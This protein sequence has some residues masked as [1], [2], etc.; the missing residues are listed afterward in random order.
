MKRECRAHIYRISIFC[1]LLVALI[2]LAGCT[3]PEKAK[4]QHLAAGEAYL[5]D[6]KYQEASLEFRNA[7]QIDE[8]LAA[9]H[10][11]LARSFEGLERFP[12]MLEELRKTVSLDK[13]N[14]DARV[15]LGTYYLGGSRGQAE[16]L[17]EAERLAKEILAKDPNHIE[18]HILMGGVL[19]A[20]NQKDK[21]FAELN[22]AVELDPKR[23]E[24]YLSL[25]KFYIVTND[26]DKAEETYRKAISIS[27]QS[28]LAHSEY[29]KFLAQAN[30]QS[31]AEAELRKAVELGPKDRGAH[32]V[33]ASYYF[34]NKQL[35]KAEEAY[36]ALAALD[37]E[38]PESQA[39]LADF[40]SAVNRGDDAVR[41]YKDILS[42][43]PDFLQA[44][45]RL[46][47]ILFARGDM[48]GAN[49]Q[50]AEVFKKDEH[51]RRALLLRAQMR[52]Q[53]RQQDGLKAAIEDLKEVLRQEPNS[54]DGLYYMA[55]ANYALG[56]FDQA[57]AF[58][59]ELEKNYPDYLP[60][61]LLQVE[62]ALS[63]GDQNDYKGAVTLA[64]DLLS[65]LDKTV[66]DNRENTAQAL[67][68]I[69]EAAYLTRGMAQLQLKNIPGARQDF[70]AARAIGPYDPVVHTSLALVALAENKPQDAIAS[71]EAA[72][73]VDA[74]NFDA[75]NGLITL[76][77]R[78]QDVGKAQATIDQAL[79]A[80]PNVA[81]LH[82]L[83]AL[84]YSF[85]HN[86]QSVEAELNRALELDPN[87]L[88]AYSGLANLYLNTKQEDRAI[89]QYQKII[90]LR[91]EN[92]VPYTLIGILEHQRKNYEVAAQNY[93]KA[94]EKDPNA[95]YAANNLA[96]LYTETGKGNLDEA[97][98]LAQGAVQKNP[99]M[100]GF[101]DTL[102][103]VYY[104]KDL[105]TAAV[106]QLRK[107]VKLNEAQ[108]REANVAP[109]ANYHYHLGMAL[110]GMGDKEA[111]RKELETAIRLADKSPFAELEDA[112]KALASM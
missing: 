14:L 26:R 47:E 13:E 48:D 107:A 104:K 20:Q 91:P 100:A 67:G 95:V 64:S 21:A 12:E 84:A 87:Y 66:P 15:K 57:R 70:E 30:R 23:V 74:T 34:V 55:R 44:R 77:A 38:K 33:L 103:W 68:R 8:K 11:G 110:K 105:I 25:A 10:W 65:R 102:G 49:V 35:D 79:K 76:Y 93:R 31:E 4:A 27:S 3:N 75:L 58:V 41:I 98:R 63:S 59:T 88:M 106:E 89:A 52:S 7:L 45:Y 51:D 83:K 50:L 86:A 42:K 19:F 53:G 9:A 108:A 6:L 32:F 60:A 112:K 99:N 96:F 29:G 37:P 54:R 69:R 62:L 17:T 18:G 61:K 24:S 81:S 72:V 82:Y 85:E 40:Y 56:L 80:Y 101:L 28:S 73:K 111:S 5:K 97:L 90:A 94:L 22:H 109:S 2:S 1:L 78:N 46:A 16:V 39:V 92:A 43:S 36:K 71:F